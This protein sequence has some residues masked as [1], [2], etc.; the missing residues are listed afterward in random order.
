MTEEVE[1]ASQL[2]ELA[3]RS[4]NNWNFLIY[5]KTS[6]IIDITEI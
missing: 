4:K 2:L 6:N 5:M 1:I 3:V